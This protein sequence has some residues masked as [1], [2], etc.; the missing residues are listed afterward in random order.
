[1]RWMRSAISMIS[2][3]FLTACAY[4][5]Y[6]SPLTAF[7]VDASGP[8]SMLKVEPGHAPG[9]RTALLVSAN[10]VVAEKD[11]QW[12]LLTL[13]VPEVTIQGVK[14]CYKVDAQQPGSTYISEIR[15]TE[16]KTPDFA[17]VLHDDG[18]DLTSIKP[19]CYSTSIREDF[20]GTVTLE[21][22]MVFGN[23]QD[24]IRIGAIELDL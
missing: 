21:L 23:T 22:K 3:I 8:S 11:S 24:R 17:A 19:T 5:I 10:Q 4:D 20:E 15:L 16:M 14:V 6:Y 7:T 18:T 1:M 9:S 2:V 13:S 12:I